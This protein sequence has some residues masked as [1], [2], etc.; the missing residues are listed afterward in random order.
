ML[1]IT[2]YNRAKYI[3]IEKIDPVLKNTAVAEL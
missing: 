3:A 2:H 1:Q